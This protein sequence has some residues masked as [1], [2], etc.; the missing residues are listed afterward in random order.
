MPFLEEPLWTFLGN[1]Q[2]LW[3]RHIGDGKR[4]WTWHGV[5][6]GLVPD[7]QLCD[8]ATPEGAIYKQGDGRVDIHDW[9]LEFTAAG[10]LLQAERLLIGRDPD[11]IARYVPLLER[12]ANLLESRRDPANDLFLAGPAANLLAPSYAGWKKPDGTYGRAYLAGLNVTFVAALDRL[13]EVEKLAGRAKAAERYAALRSH[14]RNG[15]ARLATDEGYLV[16]S[17]DPDGT[18]HGVYGAKKHGYFEASPNHDAVAFGV[19][20]DEQARRIHEKI[21]SIPGLRPHRFIIANYPS[22]DDLYTEPRGL[23]GFGTWVNGGHWSTCE[24]RMILAYYRVGAFEDA[25]LSM[26]ELLK[27]ARSFR[28]DNPLVAFGS[29]VYQPHEPINLCYDSFGPPTA[30][31]RGLFEYLYRADGLTLVPRIPPGITRIEQRFPA[32]LGSKRIYLAVEGTGPIT[33][34]MI[35][36]EPST[37]FDPSSVVLCPDGIPERAA[38]LVLRGGAKARPWSPPKVSRELPPGPTEEDLA[39]LSGRFHNLTVNEL[40]LRI[41]A[42]SH[43]GSRFLGEIDRAC[44]Y[45]RALS[46][47]EIAARAQAGPARNPSD[48]GLIADYPF[49]E[50]E[51]GRFRNRAGDSLDARVAGS[52]DV[53][54]APAGGAARFGGEGYLEIA[55]AKALDLT[56]ACTMEAWIRPG[57]LPPAG[58][59][60][61]DKSAVGTS[62]GYLL[63]THPGNSLRIIAETGT[64]SHDGKLAS[65]TWV[66]VAGTVAPD[67]TLALYID[68]SEVARKPHA[69]SQLADLPVRVE[70]LRAFHG[71][72]VAAGFGDAPQ[73]R[74]AALAVRCLD[75]AVAR[76][77]LERDGKLPLLPEPSRSAALRSYLD[78][79]R[80]LCEGLERQLGAEAQD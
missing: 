2:D 14:A 58:G 47:D 62:N 4:T 45:G 44:V 74:Q 31:I 23:W 80:R 52:I 48:A 41:G 33:G 38:V 6:H 15:L 79:T 75:A 67:G 64:V 46:A 53:V 59:R 54:D 63:D 8:A 60:I 24:A 26:K 13:V 36:G 78:A 25:R 66:H 18:R 7:G 49:D 21:A 39:L 20:G 77:R 42:D 55:P 70:A 56:E 17:I 30:L 35:N 12:C 73:A 27:F 22:L 61:I 72:R 9:G 43:G 28:M 50:I 32:R 40:P 57:E 29:A 71:R 3:F 37:S 65:A 68:G 5:D 11:E 76:A 69:S 19:V 16:K 51:D 1:S 10:L 34:V